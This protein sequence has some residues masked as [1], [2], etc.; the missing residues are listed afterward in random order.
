MSGTNR[1]VIDYI[2]VRRQ[3][4]G[5]LKDYKI[6]IGESMSRICQV[7]QNDSWL[8]KIEPIGVV[9]NIRKQ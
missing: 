9:R 7:K 8:N 3:D 1:T 2:L 4:L 6:I 5:D